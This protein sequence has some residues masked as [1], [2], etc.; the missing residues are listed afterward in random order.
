MPVEGSG[1][2]L[3]MEHPVDSSVI[4]LRHMSLWK[5]SVEMSV[6]A[7]TRLNKMPRNVVMLSQNCN[8]ADDLEF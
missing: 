4:S 3:D 8:I 7:A 5:A 1:G 6:G 2:A